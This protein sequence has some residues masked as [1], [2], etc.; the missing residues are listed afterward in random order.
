M[1]QGALISQSNVRKQKYFEKQ[2]DL[3]RYLAIFTYSL[4]LG[5]AYIRKPEVRENVR[6]C[7]RERGE[8]VLREMTPE[9]I[10]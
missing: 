8:G 5:A 10:F 6:M 3:Y 2:Q 4:D 7:V 9:T 1:V